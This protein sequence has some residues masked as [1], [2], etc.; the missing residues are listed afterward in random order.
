MLDHLEHIHL[1]NGLVAVLGLH[2]AI[3]TDLSGVYQSA[4]GTKTAMHS[5]KIG[6]YYRKVSYIIITK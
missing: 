6:Q 5:L 1:Q 4:Y 2:G 3:S